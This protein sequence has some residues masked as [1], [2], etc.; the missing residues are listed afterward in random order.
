MKGKLF[1]VSFQEVDDISCSS[2][3]PEA[4]LIFSSFQKYP[5]TFFQVHN[6]NSSTTDTALTMKLNSPQTTKELK[7]WVFVIPGITEQANTK[8]RHTCNCTGL[9]ESKK[10]GTISVNYSLKSLQ[11]TQ[12]IN[13][14]LNLPWAWPFPW[15]NIQ[16]C[17]T[18]PHV[19]THLP[20]PASTAPCHFWEKVLPSSLTKQ[21]GR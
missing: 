18:P 20:A 2:N 9:G 14:M 10:L 1:F 19:C 8:T 6:G 4:S 15:R 21:A 17:Y 5:I 12:V 3:W 16:L 7:D 13:H 11:L